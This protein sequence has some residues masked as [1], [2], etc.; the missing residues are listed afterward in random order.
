M[1]DPE[2]LVLRVI[3]KVSRGVKLGGNVHAVTFLHG[4][5]FVFSESR[6]SELFWKLL[7]FGLSLNTI[8]DLLL[9]LLL[10]L[11]HGLYSA[12]VMM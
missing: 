2:S 4:F 5:I 12:V 3:S 7:F 8:F 9:V 6:F 1:F 11:Q 10:N